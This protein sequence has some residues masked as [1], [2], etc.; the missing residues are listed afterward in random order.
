MNRRLYQIYLL[1][2]EDVIKWKHFH[3]LALC[4]GNSPVTGEFPTQKPVTRMFSL[5]LAWINSWVNNREA[6][7]LRRHH[8]H[9]D[10]TLM[11]ASNGRITW[12]I[13]WG[14][15]KKCNTK[16][17]PWLTCTKITCEHTCK[18]T[19]ELAWCYRAGARPTN[20]ISIEFRIRKICNALVKKKLYQSRR[21]FAHVMTV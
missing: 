8:A 4:A 20:D 14:Q 6:G 9:Y 17:T 5:I 15:Y 1:K 19:C 16:I 11:K 21:K 13:S 18:L 10:V 7:D 12:T 3:V 2:H